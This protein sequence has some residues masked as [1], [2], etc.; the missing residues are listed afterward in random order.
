MKG[1][2]IPVGI[3]YALVMEQRPATVATVS[4]GKNPI[5]IAVIM[6]GR[7]AMVTLT[8]GKGI[9]PNGV[10]AMMIVMAII[11]PVTASVL[12]FSLLI[13]LLFDIVSSFMLH[14]FIT[15]YFTT[16]GC[17]NQ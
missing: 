12:V 10:K 13:A 6:A 17:K 3:M 7:K 15:L 5:A 8:I 14:L 11:R 9:V 1:K 2:R 4:P 16:N